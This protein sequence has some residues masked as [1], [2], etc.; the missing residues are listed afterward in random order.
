MSVKRLENAYKNFEYAAENAFGAATSGAKEAMKANKELQLAELK[1]Q[2]ALEQSRDGKNRD[3][4]RIIEIR[5]QIIDLEHE[6]K[7]FTKNAVNDL[8][9][10]SSHGDFFESMISE[11]IEA[12][13]NGEDAMKVFEEKWSDMIDNMIMKTIVSQVLSQWV[14]TLEHG[15]NEILEK[16]TQESSKKMADLASHMTNLRTMDAGDVS[17]WIYDNDREMF[18]QIL[19]SLGVGK[20]GD[21]YGRERGNWFDNAWNTGLAQK[22]MDAYLAMLDNNMAGLQD[23]LDK[24]SLDAT[25]ELIDYY[26]EAGKEFKENYLG[27]ILDK[28]QENWNFGQD[29]KKQLSNLQQGIQGITEDTAGALEG[30]TN[31]ISQQC[32]LQSDLL[33]QIRDTI[34]GFELD[35]QVATMSQMLWQLQQSYIVQQN[36]ESL[37]QNVINPSGRAFMV[38]LA[39]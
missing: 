30:I 17:E 11:M 12:F 32:Y 1:R 36:I 16:Y 26:G 33:T 8:L 5:G 29:S 35:I 24:Q 21:M 34:L 37:L 14:K 6:I 22:I 7:D 31:G 9:G 3:E 18:N 15:A 13:K 25:G 23:E 27:Q 2:L 39:S 28:I 38:E 4:D 10:I 19:E 20:V